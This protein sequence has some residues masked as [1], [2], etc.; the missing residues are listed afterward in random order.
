MQNCKYNVDLFMIK[1]LCLSDMSMAM[2]V[3]SVQGGRAGKV[4][5]YLNADLF[6]ASN[7]LKITLIKLLKIWKYLSINS[8]SVHAY[9]PHSFPQIRI[10][11]R[12]P[13]Y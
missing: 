13:Q 3:C 6:W 4:K 11:S 5:K 8:A 9:E 10:L 1:H 7:D 2:S 12:I